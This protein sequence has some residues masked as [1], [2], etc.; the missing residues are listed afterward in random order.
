M[1]DTTT[2]VTPETEEG[3][4]VD[5]DPDSLKKLISSEDTVPENGDAVSSHGTP[6]KEKSK[7]EQS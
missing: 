7:T 4:D 5:D 1:T 6:R 2:V 3:K